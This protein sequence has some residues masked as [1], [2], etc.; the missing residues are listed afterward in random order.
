[1]RAPDEIAQTVGVD[2][3]LQRFHHIFSKRVI[4]GAVVSAFGGLDLIEEAGPADHV[5]AGLE[6]Q[7]L[8]QRRPREYRPGREDAQQRPHQHDQNKYDATCLLR[9]HEKMTG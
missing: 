8:G 2:A 1:M 6:I 7:L 9:F 3:F 4:F 5:D